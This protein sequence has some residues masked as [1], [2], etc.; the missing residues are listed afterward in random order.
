MRRRTSAS[1]SSAVTAVASAAGSSGGT[2]HPLSPSTSISGMPPTD[3]ATIGRASAML[4][5]SASG[6]GSRSA[7]CT[8]TSS[9]RTTGNGFGRKPVMR[10]ASAM[11]SAATRSR[12]ARSAAASGNAPTRKTVTFGIAARMA[13]VASTRQRGFFRQSRLPTMPMRGPGG[14]RSTGSGTDASRAMRSTSMPL[15]ATHV[16]TSAPKPPTA[17]SASASES[18]EGAITCRA[19]PRRC[20][21]YGRAE[22]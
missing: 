14:P 12:I 22:P 16:R 13:G 15:Y 10:T 19:R 17:R 11:P 1:R 6:N 5:S 18:A 2:S 3:D 9:A 8:T 20:F 7:G 21:R 4:S